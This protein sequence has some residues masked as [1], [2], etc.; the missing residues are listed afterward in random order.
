M[1]TT[2]KK[3]FKTIP[4]LL[5]A[6]LIVLSASSCNEHGDQKGEWI[7]IPPDTSA[8]ARID[9]F[10]PLQTIDQYRK[11]FTVVRDSLSR[12]NPDLFLPESEAFNKPQLL[13]LLK[14]PKCV[15]IRIYYGLKQGKTNEL[16]CMI[17]GVDE[18]GK[19]LYIEKGA[20]ASVQVSPISG[21]LEYG[22]WPSPM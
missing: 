9:H 5:V 4:H 10:I 6:T 15:G 2:F 17:V 3:S 8:L 13:E 7:P 1:A 12:S 21:G 22:Q 14:N 11:D 16:R 18:Q 19:D 20:P